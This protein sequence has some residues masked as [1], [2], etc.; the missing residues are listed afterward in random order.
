MNWA[1]ASGKIIARAAASALDPLVSV[2][3]ASHPHLRK[4]PPWLTRTV[5]PFAHRLVLADTPAATRAAA[6]AVFI[7][8]P[9]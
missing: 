5:I 3:A 1:S 6:C 7:V 2:I 4:P 9:A 8:P